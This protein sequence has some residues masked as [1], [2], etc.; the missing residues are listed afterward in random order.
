MSLPS[1]VVL[2]DPPPL[3]VN[4]GDV[5]NS[6]PAVERRFPLTCAEEEKSE[7]GPPFIVLELCFSR[8]GTVV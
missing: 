3:E 5:L 7:K 1:A 8:C 4:E 2:D 6:G